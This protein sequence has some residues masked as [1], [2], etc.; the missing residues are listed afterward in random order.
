MATAERLPFAPGLFDLVMAIRVP[1]DRACVAP[2]DVASTSSNLAN[3][4]HGRQGVAFAPGSALAPG[5]IQDRERASRSRR[6]GRSCRPEG[7][8]RDLLP[9]MGQSRTV[10]ES[11]GRCLGRVT[12]LGA[13]FVAVS[14]VKP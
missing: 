8:R 10:A 13:G 5:A 7:A 3:G 6:A 2:P 12:T 14:A 4:A 11:T 1:G 9:A